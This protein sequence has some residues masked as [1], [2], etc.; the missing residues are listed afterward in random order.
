MSTPISNELL[1]AVLAMDA[2]NRGYDAKLTGLSDAV[3]SQIGNAT[4]IGSAS[5]ANAQEHGFY[6][7]AYELDGKKIISYR[8][9]DD[10]SLLSTSSDLW[11]GW[12]QGAGI[13]STQSE[14]AIR[15]YEEI[16]GQ[17]AFKGTSNVVTTGH[18]LGGGL[19]GYVAALTS[20]QAYV[21]DA[22]PF[23]AA[24]ITRVINEQID[25]ANWITGPAELITFLTTGLSRFV[26]MPDANKVNYIS[27]DGEVLQTVRTIALT[28][29]SAFEVAVATAEIASHIEYLP[30]AVPTG[31]LA[32]PWALAVSLE[33]TDSKL[34]ALASELSSV[35]LHSQSLLVLLQYAKDNHYTDWQTIAQ[36]LLTGWFAGDDAIAKPLGLSNDQMLREIAYT[37]LEDGESP[38]GTAAIKAL[39]DDANELGHFYSLSNLSGNWA[40]AE[41]KS[42]LTHIITQFSG[43]L[44]VNKVTD[45]RSAAGIFDYDAAANIVSLDFRGDSWNI[46]ESDINTSQLAAERNTLVENLTAGFLNIRELDKIDLII[47]AA[48]KTD[49]LLAPKFDIKPTD[50]ALILCDGLNDNII[51]T[52]GN[53][54]ICT[55]DVGNDI[56]DGAGGINTAVYKGSVSDYKVTKTE[57]GL[58]ITELISGTNQ[59]DI[60]IN[61]QQVKFANQDFDVGQAQPALAMSPSSTFNTGSVDESLTLE[62]LAVH[63]GVTV[64]YDLNSEIADRISGLYEL[65]FDHLPDVEGIRSWELKVES[66]GN[67]EQAFLKLAQ[68]FLASDQ[69]AAVH[70]DLN[71]QQFIDQLYSEGFKRS[72]DLE[73]RN[74]WLNCLD[75]GTPREL[76][77]LDFAESKEMLQ[78]VGQHTSLD[79]GFW[80]I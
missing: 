53:D 13:I 11:N 22:M 42:E 63:R 57:N 38:F 66:W 17:S 29:G 60:L 44:A 77:L 43:N 51:G 67:D 56:I 65:C 14:D 76:V 12:V 21:Y 5:G 8:G 26:N 36:P 25:K 70:P 49:A 71:N 3:G 52:S 55:Y 46:G 16:A 75:N 7:I 50:S 41:I 19:A 59:T 69:Y 45:L 1:Y 34:N 27:V 64:V 61:I 4:V 28:A 73:G 39:F 24:S 62:E 37:A 80:T 40:N 10:T 78:V 33:G 6:A 58:A 9:T 72:A 18:S 32:G 35:S 68:S 30:I 48:Q 54:Y 79:D 20:G 23:G 2:Y 15:F 47:S 74:N 31:L